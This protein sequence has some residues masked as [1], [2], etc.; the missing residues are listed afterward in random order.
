MRRR[1]RKRFVKAS[2][3]TGEQQSELRV[4]KELGADR[5]VGG[6]V[7]CVEIDWNADGEGG[8]LGFS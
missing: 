8:Q 3:S 5:T 4:L 1:A 6:A 7:K 2:G